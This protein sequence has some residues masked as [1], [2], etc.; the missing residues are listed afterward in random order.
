MH[1]VYAIAVVLAF[2]AVGELISIWSRA[3]V[4]SL[5]V[6]MLGIALTTW[7]LHRRDVA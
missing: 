4:P 6:A 3:R 7:F 1:P 5:L 2:I